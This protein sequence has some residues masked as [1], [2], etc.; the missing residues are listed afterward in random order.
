MNTRYR[1]AKKQLEFADG[2]FINQQEMLLACEY[3]VLLFN[4][5]NKTFTEI[6]VYDDNNIKVNIS[7]VENTAVDRKGNYMIM[8]R[9]G[10]FFYDT[11]AKAC[12]RK[13]TDSP[14]FKSFNQYEIFNVLHDSNGYY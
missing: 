12:K 14:D 8:S 4:T 3:E 2:V 9:T 6:P 13:T 1:Y 7:R 5:R 10:I 11:V